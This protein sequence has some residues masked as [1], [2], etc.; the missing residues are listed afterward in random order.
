MRGEHYDEV[1]ADV[2]V[3]GSSPHARGT[4]RGF[5]RHEFPYGII[6]ACAGNTRIVS[7]RSPRTWDHPR[8]RGE[9]SHAVDVFNLGVGSSPHA[10]GT[11]SNMRAAWTASGIIPACAGNTRGMALIGDALRD[12]PRMRGE[13]AVERPTK[14]DRMGSSPHARGTRVRCAR[15]RVV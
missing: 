13:H 6:P 7:F 10:R 8:M 4:R 9:H 3:Q 2:F 1:S 14:Q 15:S 5:R 11:P 12:H